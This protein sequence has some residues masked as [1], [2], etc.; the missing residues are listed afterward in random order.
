MRTEFR[1]KSPYYG[2]YKYKIEISLAK[3]VSALRWTAKDENKIF[4]KILAFLD[5]NIGS[6]NYKTVFGWRHWRR[7]YLNGEVNLNKILDSKYAQ[8]IEYVYR[9]AP[10]FEDNTSKE[11][12]KPGKNALW[13]GRYPYKVVLDVPPFIDGTLNEIEHWCYENC[14][15]SYRKSGYTG[16]VSFF[17]VNPIDATGFKLMFSDR[18]IKTEMPKKKIAE[19]LLR[20]RIKEARTDLKDFLEGDTA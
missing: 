2:K 20:S 8:Y 3:H 4:N 19:N 13:Y 6:E 5:K 17:F 10:G 18:V 11:Q 7:V 15:G 16:N 14:F 12:S 9:P 1:K